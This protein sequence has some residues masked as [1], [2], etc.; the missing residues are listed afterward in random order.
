MERSATARAAERKFALHGWIGLALALIFWG[1]NWTLPGL[2]T[3]WAFFPMWL[4]Y[5][6][7][8]DALVLFRSGTSLLSRSRAK[9]AGLFLI[10]APA[11]WLFE[12]INIRTQNWIYLG[13]EFFSWW[14]YAFWAT[15]NFSVV[16]PAVFGTAELFRT[17]QFIKKIKKGPT[18][19]PD[20]PTTITFFTVGWLM[21][22]LLLVWP[23]IFF[24]FVWLSVFFI[25]E[26]V[27]IWLGNQSLTRFT[28]VGDWRPVVALWL[29]ALVC[30]FFW[31]MWNY[32]AYPK[33]IYQ[34]PGVQFAHIFEMPLL[35]Y[36]GYLPFALELYALY[37]LT[38]G[39]LSQKNSRYIQIG[40]L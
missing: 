33:W 2:R 27:N 14:E 38:V 25:I 12:A 24:P 4:G 20:L 21:L 23:R 13:S 35:G 9:Y 34:V 5:C 6:L 1:L 19:R 26:P 11:W 15:I 3:Q 37:H 40:P 30:G 16:I 28:R 32:L 17:F 7:T 36:G 18:I 22:G 8:V 10:S 39:L 31:E 29:G